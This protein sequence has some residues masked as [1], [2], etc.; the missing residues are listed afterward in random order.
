MSRLFLILSLILGL[1]SSTANA[2][3][4]SPSVFY[5]LPTQAQ[6]K[7]FIAQH[8]YLGDEGGIWI[9][10]VHGRMVFFDGQNVLP[11]RGSLLD[12]DVQQLA[13]AQNAFW[14]FIDNELYRTIPPG[15]PELVFSLTPGT[16]IEKI[17]ASAGYIWLTDETHFYTYHI[18][19]GD[20][21]TYSLMTLYQLNQ[22]SKVVVNDAKMVHTKWVLATNAGVYLSEGQ[23]FTHV[24]RSGKDYVETLLMSRQRDQLVVGTLHGALLID[25]NQPEQEPQHVGNAPVLSMVETENEYWIGTD[26]GLLVY[27][28]DTGTTVKLEGSNP[29]HYGLSHGKIYALIN[30][31]QG[32][33][34]IATDKGIR[35]F[36]RFSQKFT[37]VLMDDLNAFTPRASVAHLFSVNQGRQYL[38]SRNDGLYLIHF[39][40]GFRKQRIFDAVVHDVVQRGDVLWLAT[41]RGLLTYRL[42]QHQ[43]PQPLKDDV[44]RQP[45]QHL[46]IDA[47][48]KIWGTSRNRLWSLNPDTHEV[49]DYGSGWM[50]LATPSSKVTT[51]KMTIHSGL[52][53]GTD[54]GIYGLRNHQIRYDK[55][56]ARFGASIDIAENAAGQLWF[57]S[58]YGVFKRQDFLPESVIEPVTLIEDNIRLKC[59]LNT[60][61]GMWLG[62][63]RGMTLYNTDGQ[64]L[65]HF[66]SPHG[67]INDELRTGICA[68]GES[69]QGES[70]L[71]AST[72]GLVK[73][74]SPALAQATLPPSPIIFSQISVDYTPVLVG[75]RSQRLRL[76]YGSPASFQFGTLP[77][78]RGQQLEF[79]LNQEQW[80]PLEGA[81]LTLNHLMPGEY[82]LTVRS[83]SPQAFQQVSNQV[84]FTVLKP[85]YLSNFAV[86]LYAL[87]FIATVLLVSWW[88]S[89]MVSAMNRELKEQVVL[90]TN[91]MRHQSKAVL[92]NNQQLR[93]QIQVRHLWL[94]KL[95]SGMRPSLVKLAQQ[96]RYEQIDEVR[97]TAESLLT[98]FE[99][100]QALDGN[101][102]AQV[103][104]HDI[105]DVIDT[106]IAG[107][108]AEFSAA[109]IKIERQCL[110]RLPEAELKH[111]GIDVVFNALLAQAL[112]RMYRNQRLTI[113]CSL[114]DE[115]IVMT[116]IDCGESCEDLP[117]LLVTSGDNH[118]TLLSQLV[119][120]S[121]GDIAVYTSSERNLVELSWP[122]VS[123]DSM[124]K[125]ADWGTRLAV[126]SDDEERAWLNK[127]EHLVREH[128]SDAEFSTSEAAKLLFVSE[129][130]LQRRFKTATHKTFKE[131]LTEYRL[132]KACQVL[133][134]GQ[135][136]AQVAF[137]CG[138]NDP[139]YFSQRFKHHFGVSPTQF[140]EDKELMD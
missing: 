108:S 29:E 72:M 52:L 138:F 22:A 3:D 39:F 7:V 88:R 79:R 124:A 105:I 42:H 73:V 82:V 33:I 81:Q 63:S 45:V 6:G 74:S 102:E 1:L 68:V 95:L 90:K 5:P 113:Q 47:E 23:G 48:G 92:S 41:N 64:I 43:G 24:Q 140:I 60:Q 127:V 32:G 128:Y 8:L 107:W 125:D 31:Q 117:L 139:S 76:V 135:K 28:V 49:T 35:Y 9:H 46:E 20:F 12:G 55:E 101:G 134:E 19:S 104:Q 27:S 106:V 122:Q 91:Q 51:L 62:S 58:S 111:W 121:G 131:Y 100:F 112:K 78:A 84:T 50:S 14:T 37:R 83:I 25:I 126:S 13:Y 129:R 61:Q 123:Q 59:L 98:E 26:S 137:C 80:Q 94:D 67:L 109:G 77:E 65:N 18:A 4:K 120:L 34:W 75:S 115:R 11:R 110:E 17:G 10:D 89:R 136:V 86:T 69:A 103:T 85:W 116:W 119:E 44:L 15:E 96:A 38:M 21:Q 97:Q 66:G 133:L 93:K 57:V 114:R 87:A 2:L 130:S 53:I 30:D 54:H 40:K 99:Q 70:L 71:F 56:S 16:V 132:E 118:S 36:S